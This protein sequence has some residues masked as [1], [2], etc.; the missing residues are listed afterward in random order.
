MVSDIVITDCHEDGRCVRRRPMR[1]RRCYCTWV[2]GLPPVPHRQTTATAAT[3]SVAHEPVAAPS[4]PRKITP[5]PCQVDEYA[6]M[7][8]TVC[9]P[10]FTVGQRRHTRRHTQICPLQ[11]C[12]YALCTTHLHTH[13]HTHTHTPTHAYTHTHVNKCRRNVGG[14]RVE[15]LSDD[16]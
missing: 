14:I 5:L 10:P 12:M 13:T 7:E 16:W 6:T 8:E 1:R 3:E 2:T 4:T 9:V 11:L 15:R